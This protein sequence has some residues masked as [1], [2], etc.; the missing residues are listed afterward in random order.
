L[1]GKLLL[2]LVANTPKSQK[3]MGGKKKV[4]EKKSFALFE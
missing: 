2:K 3:K 1:K 4:R